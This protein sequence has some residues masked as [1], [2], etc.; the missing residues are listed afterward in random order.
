MDYYDAVLKIEQ[1]PIDSDGGQGDQQVKGNRTDNR[2]YQACQAVFKFLTMGA[3][4]KV[5]I[6][7]PIISSENQKE[8]EK[9][10]YTPVDGWFSWYSKNLKELKNEVAKIG[11]I[12]NRLSGIRGSPC[13]AG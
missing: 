9:A 11:D 10:Y 2:V 8:Q 4:K 1:Q 5:F 13:L 12:K 3:V 6:K 7:E